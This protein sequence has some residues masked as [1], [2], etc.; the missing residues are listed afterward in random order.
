[1]A[2]ERPAANEYGAYYGNYIGKVPDGDIF[3]MFT[4]QIDT[5]NHMLGKYTN[6]QGDYRFGE[7]EWSIKEV[8]GHLIDAER[9]FA[10]RALQ[11]A[12][13]NPA[14]LPGFDQD[15]FVRESNYSQRSL[16]D[17]LQEFELVRRS[18]LLLFRNLSPE[19]YLRPGTA[20]NNP[21]TVRAL[22]YVMV[23]HV[24]H[25]IGSLHSDYGVP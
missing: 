16:S 12:R 11:F 7:K 25:H 13:G 2:V 21:F 22:L 5:L 1:M 10:Y 17:L 8:V 15:D 6:E 9:I 14:P 19:I 18:N 3:A 4:E 24:I 20:S 23:G